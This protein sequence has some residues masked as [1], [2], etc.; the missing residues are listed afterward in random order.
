[1]FLSSANSTAGSMPSLTR[2]GN[3]GPAGSGGPQ[4]RRAP[5]QVACAHSLPCRRGDW[6]DL[7]GRPLVE[8]V[9][10]VNKHGQA[11]DAPKLASFWGQVAVAEVEENRIAFEEAE[12]LTIEDT[13]VVPISGE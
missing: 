12:I 13:T 9:V 7:E 6:G 11:Q 8:V 4:T 5:R 3:V 1:M 10:P 2:N